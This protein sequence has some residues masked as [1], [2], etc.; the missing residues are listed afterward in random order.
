M[1]DR[2]RAR[3][4]TPDGAG[5]PGLGAVGYNGLALQPEPELDEYDDTP[6]WS[7][8]WVSTPLPPLGL[9]ET[10]N[11]QYLEKVRV[12]ITVEIQ[13]LNPKDGC[14]DGKIKCH[15]QFRTL[16]DN[17]RTTPRH[18]VPGLRTP[19]LTTSVEESRVWRNF[20]GDTDVTIAWYGITVIS[21]SGNEIFEVNDFPFDRQVLEV[22][23][24]ECVW[25]EEKGSDIY[26]D[27]MKI[28][29]IVVETSSLLP[30]WDTYPAVVEP[31]A[32]LRPGSGPSY[33]SRFTVKLRLQRKEGYYVIQIFMVSTMI[34]VASLLPLALAPG[35]VHVGD[36]LG[37]HSGGL[38]T[39]VSFKYSIASELPSVPYQTFV[40]IY[41][42]TQIITL[43]VVSAE[44]L[45]AYKLVEDG[46]VRFS[47]MNMAEDMLLYLI[48]MFWLMYFLYVAFHKK[49]I[50]WEEVLSSQSVT[51]EYHDSP[52]TSQDVHREVS[53][54]FKDE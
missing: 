50:P 52:A 40:S 24:L 48:L 17:D 21:F 28:V 29:S 53:N 32:I 42:T 36:R 54:K 8:S 26:F 43:V 23:L 15:W 12:H 16:N 5:V 14:Y 38:L 44:A 3:I 22:D 9:W 45:V 49:R 18:R 27:S 25:R 30:E 4:D 6:Q 11:V 33:C 37:L 51:E 31:R 35:D 2:T 10:Q 34:T 20:D 13:C 46:I 47:H 7:S 1:V 41:L 39:L 19:R